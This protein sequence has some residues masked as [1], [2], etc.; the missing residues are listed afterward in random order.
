M[1]V[2]RD[3]HDGPLHDATTVLGSCSGQAAR[4]QCGRVARLP[5]AGVGVWPH[6]PMRAWACGHTARRGRRRVATLPDLGVGVWPHCP[7]WALACAGKTWG[8]ALC[9]VALVSRHGKTM[10]H[11]H[12]KAR[13][14]HR[15]GLRHGMARDHAARTTGRA[16]HHHPSMYQCTCPRVDNTHSLI[17]YKK[18]KR[19]YATENQAVFLGLHGPNEDLGAYASSSPRVY[20][21]RFR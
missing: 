19:T 5:D 11:R 2:L 17:P 3:L 12:G 13:A 6:W 7:T 1:G 20:S 9:R 15:T 16:P 21:Q 18:L 10:G 4:H 8:A 14:R